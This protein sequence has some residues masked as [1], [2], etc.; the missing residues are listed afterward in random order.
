MIFPIE[1]FLATAMASEE[2]PKW[3]YHSLVYGF[4]LAMTWALVSLG[5]VLSG[6]VSKTTCRQWAVPAILF[7]LLPIGGAAYLYYIDFVPVEMDGTKA[8]APLLTALL[9]PS[10]PAMLGV[11]TLV[12]LHYRS[13][14]RVEARL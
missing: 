6:R 1:A 5:M 4:I 2:L 14:R 13:P 8:S 9:V 10:L 12:V 11:I 3:F 7:S